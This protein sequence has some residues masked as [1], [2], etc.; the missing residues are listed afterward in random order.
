[1]ILTTYLGAIKVLIIEA[2]EA[3]PIISGTSDYSN[4]LPTENHNYYWFIAAELPTY[5]C[6]Q[7]W[8]Y[9]IFISELI[10]WTLMNL[11]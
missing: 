1:M 9:A 11:Y 4:I 2:L 8:N 3:T 7:L 10:N 6:T 5:I